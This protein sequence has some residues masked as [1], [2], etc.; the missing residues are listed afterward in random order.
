[1][2]VVPGAPAIDERSATEMR[3]MV[4]RGQL[5]IGALATD[6]CWATYRELTARGVEFTEEPE[7]RFYGI[8]AGF[9]DPFGNPW[10]LTQARTLG[11]IRDAVAT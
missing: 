3:A 5:G 6:D 8:D 9:R 11:A 4:A 2:L 7:D 10:R 1:M